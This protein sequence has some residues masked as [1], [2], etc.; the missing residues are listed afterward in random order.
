LG[1]MLSSVAKGSLQYEGYA[2]P[3]P[4]FAAAR[5][6]ELTGRLGYGRHAVGFASFTGNLDRVSRYP[7][8]LW[9]R[10]HRCWETL[11]CS[12]LICRWFPANHFQLCG[13]SLL[14][15]SFTHYGSCV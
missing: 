7:L 13:R 4:F 5:S 15:T 11:Q 2:P 1:V 14:P 3:W 9:F 12:Q 6:N 8:R 10:W